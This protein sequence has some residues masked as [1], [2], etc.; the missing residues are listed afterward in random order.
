MK[1]NLTHNNKKI[2]EPEYFLS[3][4][5]NPCGLH[6]KLE[7]NEDN[8]NI[9]KD[10]KNNL[11]NINLSL[12]FFFVETK[13]NVYFFKATSF[14]DKITNNFEFAVLLVNEDESLNQDFNDDYLYIDCSK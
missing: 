13:N 7:T 5:Q 3:F 12:S 6:F 2:I 14:K 8:V 10:I 9:I 1:I 11:M 4:Y